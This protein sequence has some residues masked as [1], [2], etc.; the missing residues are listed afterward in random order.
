[1]DNKGEL[2]LEKVLEQADPQTVMTARRVSRSIKEMI[3]RYRLQYKRC[4]LVNVRFVIHFEGSLE[5]IATKNEEEQGDE[6]SPTPIIE[7]NLLPEY[8]EHCDPEEF[9]FMTQPHEDVPMPPIESLLPKSWRTIEKVVIKL[10]SPFESINNR[11]L[12]TFFVN[13]NYMELRGPIPFWTISQI[14]ELM[15]AVSRLKM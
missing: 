8:F 12:F 9:N 6:E 10:S 15:P 13:A 7:F 1:M 2:V 11:S 4:P 3:D 14:L 5:I